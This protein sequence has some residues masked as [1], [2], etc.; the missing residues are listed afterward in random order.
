MTLDRPFMINLYWGGNIKY[1]NGIIKGDHSTFS[2]SNIVRHK[3]G[4][5]EFKDLCYAHVGVEK[6]SHKLNISL[7]YQF[8]GQSTISRVINDSSLDVMYYLAENVANY[9]GQ[10][11]IEFEKIMSPTS[12]SFVDLLQNF[13]VL[14]PNPSN[15]PFPLP[16]C[17]TFE[18]DCDEANSLYSEDNSSESLCV[19]EDSDDDGV[20][21]TPVMRDEVEGDH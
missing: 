5:E 20:C 3:M 8:G 18:G 13:E 6:A 14:E 2:T 4:Y 15:V 7:C 16:D 21:E 10:V 17:G 12:T 11:L 19:G 9:W 1:E